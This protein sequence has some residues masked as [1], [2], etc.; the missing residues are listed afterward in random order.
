MTVPQHAPQAGRLLMGLYPARYRAAHGADI[1]A[2]FAETTGGL[3]RRAVLRERFDLAAH[4]LRLRLRIG[5]TDPVGRVLAGAAPVALALAAGRCLFFLLT[6][7]HETAYRLLHPYPNLGRGYAVLGAAL[8]LAGTLPWLLALALTVLGRWRAARIT[9]VLAALTGAGIQ[10]WE[11]VY[12]MWEVGFLVGLL[13]IGVLGL[14]A[15]ADLVDATA[16]GRWEAAGLALGVGLPMTVVGPQGLTFLDDVDLS[17][18]VLLPAWLCT[19]TAV[20]LLLRLSGRRPDRLRAAGV[21]LGALPWLSYLAFA[22]VDSP[23]QRT[24]LV[25]FGGICL[26]PLG[27]AVAVAGVVH[28]VRRARTGGTAP[29]A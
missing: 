13:L 8:L 29:S 3:P 9:G 16:R 21:A 22:L 14:L 5:P 15:P 23:G 2:V 6:Q 12:A 4:A 18:G 11:G 24:A 19:V 17:V 7:L 28:L 10:W 27:T 1:A 26:A 20:A 25:E